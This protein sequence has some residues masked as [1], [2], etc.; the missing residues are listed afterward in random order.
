MAIPKLR[1]FSLVSAFAETSLT[2]PDRQTGF[3]LLIDYRLNS[4]HSG[5]DAEKLMDEFIFPV[6]SPAY[7]QGRD[8]Q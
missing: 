7:M 8:I 3:D 6:A 1:D 2:D 5:Q 4:D